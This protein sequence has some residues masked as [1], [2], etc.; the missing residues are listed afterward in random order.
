MVKKASLAWIAG[1]FIALTL[2]VFSLTRA[3]QAVTASSSSRAL[4]QE[5]LPLHGWTVCVDLGVGPVPGQS[6]NLQRVR[7][8]HGDGWQVDTFCLEPAKPVPQVGVMCSMVSSTDFWCGDEVQQLREYQIQQT[9]PPAPPPTATPSP[10]STTTPVPTT[11]A[12]P[13]PVPNTPQASST[14]IVLQPTVF[15]RPSPGGAGNSGLL[16]STF[17]VLAGITLLALAIRSQRAAYRSRK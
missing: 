12:P 16:F 9:P 13:P 4:S 3:P 1:F 15:A 2:L 6:G 7:M 10:T 5:T 8:C 14:P 17:F 11:A